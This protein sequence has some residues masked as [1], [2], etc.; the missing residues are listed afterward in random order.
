VLEVV[1][2]KT[3]IYVDKELWEKFKL[4]ASKR[5]TEITRMLEDMIRDEMV[6]SFLNQMIADTGESE[7]YKIEFEPVEPEKGLV[8]ELVRD[9]R[10][11]R[12]NSVS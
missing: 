6:D 10:D 9:M 3:S 8:S 5:G 2:V 11:G 7:D 1:K 4:Q 12:D